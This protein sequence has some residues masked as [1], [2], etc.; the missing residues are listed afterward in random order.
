MN[1]DMKILRMELLLDN[2]KVLDCK[3]LQKAF[4]V[5]S[6]QCLEPVECYH[7]RGDDTFYFLCQTH[8]GLERMGFRIIRTVDDI[9]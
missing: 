4:S 3:E 6:H 1:D 5:R 9:R 7:H 2:I 8:R